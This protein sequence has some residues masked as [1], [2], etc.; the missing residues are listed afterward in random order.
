MQTLVVALSDE[1]LSAAAVSAERRTRRPSGS[2]VG[3]HG[4]RMMLLAGV[5]EQARRA[6]PDG[7]PEAHGLAATSRATEAVTWAVTWLTR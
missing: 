4:G 1:D 6:D 7:T 3:W 2:G 5:A